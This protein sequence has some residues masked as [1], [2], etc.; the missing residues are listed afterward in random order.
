MKG[1]GARLGDK[2]ELLEISK[3]IPSSYSRLDPGTVNDMSCMLE[4]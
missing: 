2:S 4:F 1:Q 3:P